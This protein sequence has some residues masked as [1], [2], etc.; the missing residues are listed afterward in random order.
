MPTAWTPS[1]SGSRLYTTWVVLLFTLV[2]TFGFVD[3]IIVQALVQPIKTELRVSDSHMGLFGGLAFAALYVVLSIPIARLAERRNRLAIVCVSTALWSL[4]TAVSAF[5]NN[6]G[7]LL[8]A[9][10]GVGIGEAGSTPATF[11]ILSDTFPRERRASALSIYSLAVPLG[12]FLGGALGGYVAH[13]WGWRAAFQVVGLPGVLLALL[14]W[15]TLREP[16][17][18]QHDPGVDAT[19]TP[20]FSAVL[21]RFAA[22]PS[23]IHVV[24]GAMFSTVG[25]YGISYFVAAY[26]TRHFGLDYAQAGLRLGLVSSVPA[27]L[28]I[29]AGGFL[30][31]W[32]GRRAAYWYALIPALG[33]LLCVPFYVAAFRADTANT[34]TALLAVAALCQYAYIPAAAAITQNMMAPRM[35]A[36]ATALTGLL[37]TLVGQGLGPWLVGTLSDHVGLQSALAL[38]SLLYLWSGVH[39]ALGART[40][41]RDFSR[42]DLPMA[43]QT[44]T[45]HFPAAR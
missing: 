29:L 28:S 22:R 7:Q 15:L 31:D 42:E 34:T 3:R 24:L 26:L 40:L 19:H 43:V 32:A 20:A 21:R 23:L 16:P 17:R 13:R 25:G 44:P 45:A 30:T 5:A 37:Y 8:L 27:A 4:A 35:R 1:P 2:A 33:S 39:L 14:L 9:R 6:F 36:T 12:A 41:G 18:G 38:W 11:S 10:V